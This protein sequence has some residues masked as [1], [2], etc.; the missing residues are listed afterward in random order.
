MARALSFPDSWDFSGS[1]KDQYN[2]VANA[3]PPLLAKAIAE[4]IRTVIVKSNPH[5]VNT[6]SSLE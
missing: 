1:L 2:Q 5:L 6:S 3:L 4:E